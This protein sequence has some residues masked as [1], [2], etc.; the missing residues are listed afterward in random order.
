MPNVGPIL[1]A[2]DENIANVM[3]CGTACA[4]TSCAHRAAHARRHASHPNKYGMPEIT[5]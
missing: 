2:H 5:Y 1:F 4:M 3:P